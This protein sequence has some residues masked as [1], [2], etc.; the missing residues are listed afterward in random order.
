[1]TEAEAFVAAIL[2]DPAD[3]TARLVYAD[4]LQEHGDE[5]RAAFI[6]T[7]CALANLVRPAPVLATDYTRS[8]E[9]HRLVRQ[10]ERTWRR[11]YRMDVARFDRG[12][13][14]AVSATPAEFLAGVAKLFA[15]QPVADVYIVGVEPM[16]LTDGRYGWAVGE[17]TS[18]PPRS[19]IIA[20]STYLLPYQLWG[21]HPGN[22]P[23]F[24]I[25]DTAA[26][27]HEALSQACVAYGRKLAARSAPCQ[28]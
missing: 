18:A 11:T 24:R 14:E 16:R 12:F 20:E 27:C 13:I 25:H 17:M 22:S 10:F 26:A 5:D 3:D 1:M 23:L 8:V 2:A 15:A 21:S 9:H 19:I 6:R 4:W 7:G 28:A